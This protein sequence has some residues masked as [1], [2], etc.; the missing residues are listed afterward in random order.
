MESFQ[1]RN[2]S[3]EM[4]QAVDRG[5]VRSVV[6][7]WRQ[8]GLKIALVPTM[9]NLHEGH[10]ALVKVA[11]SEADRV[12]TSIYVNPTQFGAGEDY[13]SYP[14]TLKADQAA[15]EESGCDLL[16]VPD[17]ATVYPLGFENAI[18]MVAPPDIASPLEGRSRP[19]HFDGVLTVVARLFNLVCPDLAVFG[20]KDYQQLLLVRR[21]VED[22]SFGIR[23]IPVP[24]AREPNGLALS[25]R[26]HY[27]AAAQK[28][29]AAHLSSVLSELVE[30]INAEP[31]S[32]EQAE[33]EAAARL[34][35]LGLRVDYVAVRRAHDLAKPSVGAGELRV[36]AAV[37]CGQ[38]RLI[39]NMK[40]N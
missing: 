30:R 9:G 35:Q 37:W 29:A 28:E 1:R 24:T 19:D 14:K 3:T 12:V 36:L 21:M 6:D 7:D 40:T 10:L 27:L 16:F 5:Q 34:Q 17:H 23:I 2:T 11:R 15:L 22:L 13:E 33:K 4:L 8:Q 25:S 38:T 39:D 31:A 20:E 18:R 26:N 32:W